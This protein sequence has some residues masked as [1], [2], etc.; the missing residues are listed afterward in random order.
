MLDLRMALSNFKL[1]RAIMLI[2][3]VVFGCMLATP[4]FAEEVQADPKISILIPLLAIGIYSLLCA[5]IQQTW[6]KDSSYFEPKI[7]KRIRLLI[8]IFI[9]LGLVLRF[10][11]AATNSGYVNDLSLFHYWGNYAYDQ[12]LFQ[13]YHGEFFIDYPPGYIYVLYVIAFLQ[14][15]FNIQ[16]G[17][18]TFLV[19]YKLPAIIAD[20]IASI[21]LFRLAI[22]KGSTPLSLG[23]MLLYWFNPVVLLDGAVWGQVDSIFGLSLIVSIYLFVNRR[24]EA[25]SILFAITALIKP[26]AFIFMPIV[27]LALGYER[28]WKKLGLSALFGFGTF[29]IIALPLFLQGDG[30]KQL[31]E[32]YA[33]TLSSYAYGTVN[34]YN[35][36]SLFG[37]NW[38]PLDEKMLGIKLSVWGALAIV[39]AVIYAAW[40][41]LLGKQK[42]E[43]FYFVAATLIGIVFVFVTKMHERYMFVILP[44]LLLAFLEQRDKRLLHLFY[45]F[46]IT[47]MLNLYA[48]LAFSA[49]TTFIPNDGVAIL[50]AAGNIVLVCY[51]LYVGYDLFIRGNYKLHANRTEKERLEH[52]AV[53]VTNE[54]LDKEEIKPAKRWYDIGMTKKDWMIVA[55]VTAV[56]SI[57][58]FTNLGDLKAPR[59]V[60]H[61][62]EAG[63]SVLIDLGKA[64][65]VGRIT[66][67]G[68]VGQGEYSYAL[69]NE[70]G[71]W[72]NEIV[73]TADH[74]SVFSW[75]EENI[76]TEARY[77]RLTATKV[78]FRIHELAVYEQGA[79]NQLAVSIAEHSS[80]GNDEAL[81]DEQ[82]LAQYHHTYKHG[83][84]FDEVYHARTAYEHIEGIVAYESTHPPL[85]KI[86]I[87][88]G[89]QLFGFGPFGWRFMG[90]L[91]GVLMLPLIYMMTKAILRKTAFATCAML[92]LAVDFMHFAQTRIAT[93]DVYAVFF[94][95]LMFFFMNQYMS[96]N[97]YREKLRHT[98]IPLGLAGLSFGLGVASKWIVLYGGAGLA[99]MLAIILWRRYSEYRAAKQLLSKGSQKLKESYV[100][101]LQH[102]TASFAP[103]TIATLAICIVFYIIIPVAIYALANIPVLKPLPS[104][105]TLNALIDYQVNMY[106]YHSQLVSSHPFSSTWWEWP[107]MKRPVWYYT[108][109]GLA[110]GLRSTIVTLGNPLIWWVGICAMI[111]TVFVSIRR[112][113]YMVMSIFIAYG[114]QYIPWMLV[115]RETFIYHYFA[116]VPFIIISIVYIFQNLEER[117]NRWKYGRWIY[118]I[119]AIILFVMFY[120]ALSGTVVSSEYVQDYL[121]WFPSWLF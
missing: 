19:L 82:G 121:R 69:A 103:Y 108:D 20:T 50:C 63:Q 32:L 35:L 5:S 105:Y 110:E 55:A 57:I 59:T 14:D 33:G 6:M 12:G 64:E 102:I 61:P 2:V 120:P 78:G 71:N 76:E 15:V 91:F 87:A 119:L 36:Y 27:L 39:A 117:N 106:N 67:F 65:A 28:S 86:I 42:R 70:L 66:T 49:Q 24:I 84:Y 44:L 118:T 16:Y 85:G 83:S 25:G 18:A 74:V 81:I 41:S 80:T 56:Y 90:T 9:V 34:A 72:S 99:I 77:I 1:V 47:N 107:F 113:Q 23:V 62:T 8:G 100:T 45:G 92:L 51:M 46:S 116:M 3:I 97:F 37:F 115:P 101:E 40:I 17:T 13:L 22:K 31:I 11:L 94:I 43:A 21:F 88:L 58:A 48:V 38:L 4:V 53:V 93:I 60:W 73:V 109:S 10:Y 104:G 95:M 68:G 29:L 112:K 89:I 26:Q 114:A 7:N 98:W 75:H 111:A 52:S 79:G 54:L 30:I 96:L